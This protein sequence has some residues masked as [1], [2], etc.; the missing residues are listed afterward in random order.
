VQPSEIT[1]LKETLRQYFEPQPD[2]LA[3]YLFGSLAEG[4][5]TPASDVDV[6]VLCAPGREQFFYHDRQLEL[7][8]KLPLLLK[9][10]DVD[11]VV[12]N[13]A[14]SSE[15]KYSIVQ[16]GEVILDK[17]TDLVEYEIRVKH[18]YYDHMAAL[19][20]AGLTRG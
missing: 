3:V 20:R 8:G 2:I 7:A 1:A 5:A 14:Q 9:R 19:R 17:T 13:A 16:D 10:D 12:L 6:A 18:E 11:V 4:T 15:L